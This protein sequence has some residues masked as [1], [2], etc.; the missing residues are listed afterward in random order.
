MNTIEKLLNTVSV[1]TILFLFVALFAAREIIMLISWFCDTFGIQTKWTSRRKA[2]KEMLDNHERRLDSISTDVKATKDKLNVV[3]QM[4]VE[5]QSKNDASERAKLKD[6]ISQSYRYYHER[7]KWNVME[8]EAFK[9]LVD[10][11]EAHGGTNSFVHE[12]C[13]PESYTWKIVE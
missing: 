8:K 11:Y 13:V 2:E 10:D 7:G 12:I 9:D 1:D 4:L 5:M 6:R 3:S